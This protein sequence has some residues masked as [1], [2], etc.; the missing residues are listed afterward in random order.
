VG[1]RTRTS[2]LRKTSSHEKAAWE[3]S[4]GEDGGG[5]SETCV[6]HSPRPS[7][8]LNLTLPLTSTQL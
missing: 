7:L 6:V 3:G 1:A 5:M 4:G 8:N 2:F